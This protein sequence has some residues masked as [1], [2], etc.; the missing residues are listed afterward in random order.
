MNQGFLNPDEVLKQLKL[1]KEM[2]A[3]DF[4]CGSGGWVLPLAKK[5]EEGTIYALDIL[6]EPLSALKARAKLEKISN[7]EIIRADVEKRTPLSSNSIDL[8]L[9]TDLLFEC[10]DKKIILEEGKR[11]LKPDGKILVVDWKLNAPLGPEKGRVSPDEVKK[12]AEE[13]GLKVEKPSTRA[14]LGAGEFE[15]GIYHWGLIFTK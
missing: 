2:I 12:I 4:G 14:K 10:E 5:L 3:A 6:E 7:I 11:A 15:T 8:V 13:I 9:M 1:K